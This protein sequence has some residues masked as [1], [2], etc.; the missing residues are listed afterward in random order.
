[1]L[2]IY[3]REFKSYFYSMTGSIFIAFLTFMTGIYFMAYN[4]NNGYPYFSYSLEGVMFI[5][6]VAVPILTM[7]SFSEERRSRTDQLLLTSPVSV[8]KMVMGKYFAMVTVFLI[9]CVLF[10]AYSL[11]ISTQGTAYFKNDYTSILVFFL[12]GCVY[13]AIGS[14]IS[15]MTE[16]QII[17]AIGTFGVLMVIYLWD[18]LLSFLPSSAFGGMA[19]IWMMLTLCVLFVYNMTKNGLLSVGIE[20]IG[21]IV[22]IVIYVVDS[23]LYEGILSTIFE[24]FA[25][26]STF[27][28]VAE[29]NLLD[30]G[31]VVMYLTM[32]G[33]FLFLTV[34]SIQKR[35]FS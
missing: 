2:A 4:L 1:M 24:K 7:R 18:G 25:L 19:G 32:I 31:G 14:F 22:L 13:I 33:V 20:G 27:T 15:A 35:R 21:T 16:S 30:I 10:C 17:A 12:L 23:S 11:I 26:V 34:Q 5:F 6:L 28:S 29:N 9:P 3:K 8:G